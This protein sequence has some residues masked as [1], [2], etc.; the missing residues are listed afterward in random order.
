M[1]Q[2]NNIR[3]LI[4]AAFVILLLMGV[5]YLFDLVLYI[6]IAWVLSLIGDPFVDYL[7]DKKRGRLKMPRALAS[8]VIVLVTWTVV[9]LVLSAIIPLVVKQAQEVSELKPEAAIQNLEKPLQTIENWYYKYNISGDPNL[10]FED[11]LSTKILSFLQ[12]SDLSSIFGSLINT[13]GNI[14]V[15][16]F[17][18]TFIAFF[19]LKEEKLFSQGLMA[20]FPEKY[21]NKIRTAMKSIQHLLARYFIGISIESTLIIILDTLGLWIVGVEF[22]YAIIIAVF[23]GVINVVPYVGPLLGAAFGL[24]FTLV[25]HISDQFYTELLPLLGLVLLVMSIVQVIDNIVFQP[26]IY[27]NSVSAHPLEVFLVISI[28]GSLAGVTGMILAIPSYTVG[29]VI[30]KEF[31]NQFRL[32]QKLTHNL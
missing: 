16:V 1:I 29:R 7:S 24:V 17:S 25:T 6:L 28:S 23:A 12:L 8:G 4:V 27:S 18:I 11:F 32:V 22:K 31:F 3:Y 19:F 20:F 26:L 2:S 10:K 9:I 5:W 14:F 30:A 21:D 15:A 13:L